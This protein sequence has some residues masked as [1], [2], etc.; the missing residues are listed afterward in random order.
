MVSRA[1]YLLGVYVCQVYHGR[2]KYKNYQTEFHC[3]ISS[4]ALT[5]PPTQKLVPT[6]PLRLPCLQCSIVSISFKSFYWIQFQILGNDSNYPFFLYKETMPS[7]AAREK[8]NIV[9]LPQIKFH[10]IN[11]FIFAQTLLVFLIF[12]KMFEWCAYSIQLALNITGALC[13]YSGHT[14][15]R[16]KVLPWSPVIILTPSAHITL[17]GIA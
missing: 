17:Y 11:F 12:L 16:Y 1:P 8:V 15:T 7:W 2:V 14:N 9:S 6:I 4:H 13:K 3:Y 10:W 5:L